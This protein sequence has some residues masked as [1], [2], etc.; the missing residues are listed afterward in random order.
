MRNVFIRSVFIL[1]IGS[2]VLSGC[3]TFPREKLT[4]EEK[5][6][7]RARKK[8][9]S[10]L[11]EFPNII[12]SDSSSSS[13]TTKHVIDLE[14]NSYDPNK[15]IE[16]YRIADSLREEIRKKCPDLFDLL[17]GDPLDT[18]TQTT[19]K[20]LGDQIIDKFKKS[21]TIESL[22]KPVTIDTAGIKVDISAKGNNLKVK[23]K[24]PVTIIKNTTKAN[25]IMPCQECPEVGYWEA[26][27]KLWPVLVVL[28][29][30]IF[31]L[32]FLVIIMR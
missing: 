7:N 20:S 1:A 23:V 16:V 5:R 8:V 19:I 15:E 11:K 31:F 13:D 21:I 17:P 26:F 25:S 10:I 24:L 3:I 12:Q 22:L 4:K 6:E 14:I 30:I 29:G 32:F 9:A 27:C 2:L 18:L 28:V